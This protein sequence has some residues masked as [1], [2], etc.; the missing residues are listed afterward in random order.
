MSK[1]NK[2]KCTVIIPIY[3][4]LEIT[5]RAIESALPDIKKNK[6]EL[7]LIN[8]CSPT[9]KM[10]ET[11]NQIHNENKEF[12]TL[13]TNDK[14]LGFV[15]SV[16]KAFKLVKKTDVIIL[17]S[18]VITPKNWLTILLKESNKYPLLGTLTPLSNNSTITSFPLPNIGSE[19]LLDFNVD[20]INNLFKTDLP[21]VKTHT[22][23]GFCMLI[24]QKCFEKTGFFNEEL[25]GKGYGEE[26]DY[27]LRA[28]KKGFQNYITPNLYCHHVG[29]VS[30]GDS[31]NQMIENAVNILNKK[32]PE[33]S[34]KIQEWILS[35]PLKS[36]RIIRILEAAKI[37]KIPFILSITHS[38]GGG[39]QQHINEIIK[40]S[41]NAI[42]FILKG[43]SSKKKSLSLTIYWNDKLIEVFENINLEIIL[44]I[45]NNINFNLIHLHHIIGIPL[46]VIEWLLKE[47]SSLINTFHDFY[48]INGNTNLTDKN[49]NFAGINSKSSDHLLN[50]YFKFE[51]NTKINLLIKKIIEKSSANI[52][53]S[54]STLILF[55]K[56]YGFIPNARVIPHENIKINSIKKIINKKIKIGLIGAISLEKGACLAE[57][58][59]KLSK[60][61]NYFKTKIKYLLIGYSCFP[62]GYLEKTGEYKNE[63]LINKIFEND[64]DGIIFTARWPETFSYTLSTA[65]ESELPIIAPNIGA[66]PERLS[67]YPN[68]LIYSLEDDEKEITQKIINFIPLKNEKIV[69]THTLSDF[70]SDEYYQLSSF[71]NKKVNYYDLFKLLNSISQ[72]EI[73]S[74][75]LSSLKKKIFFASKKIYNNKYLNPLFKKLTKKYI[76]K[77]A[78]LLR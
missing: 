45:L 1:V 4:N 13:I 66:F 37:K 63:D 20:D 39:T 67:N 42:N 9:E 23:V 65:I 76:N 43:F 19:L 75:A 22:G 33:Y 15:K 10:K 61:D 28:I 46:P 38:L 60:L 11:L 18:D 49:G 24:K 53:P 64:L 47:K 70:Y 58:L 16:N 35:N 26:N 52:F 29:N 36:T 8:D 57:G 54:N 71:N 55:E 72:K 51:D 68:K 74:P 12:I 56:A 14:N 5:K 25:F 73:N 41:K 32:Y 48:M 31:S 30:F 2:K 27:C 50:Q 21:S 6:S 17:N 3:K 77:I 34:I 59:A 69:N 62:N 44:K 40:N 78:N 7:I